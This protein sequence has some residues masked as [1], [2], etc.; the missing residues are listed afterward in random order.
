MRYSLFSAYDGEDPSA[1]AGG[2]SQAITSFDKHSVY[3][4]D[5]LRPCSQK[6]NKRREITS[7]Q[8]VLTSSQ[9]R[10]VPRDVASQAHRPSHN[11]LSLPPASRTV[12]RTGTFV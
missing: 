11:G 6:T 5:I 8:A 12:T 9:A 10:C 3:E 7:V 2:N 1:Q 4:C